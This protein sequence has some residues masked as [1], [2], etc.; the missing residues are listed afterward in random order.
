MKGT[1]TAGADDASDVD[2]YVFA[3]QAVGKWLTS[4]T[5]F[6]AGIIISARRQ[7]RLHP[8]NVD[9]EVFETERELIR[10]QPL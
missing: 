3:R 7:R 8:G 2:H 5:S 10:I 9:I 1:P 4:L 6:G